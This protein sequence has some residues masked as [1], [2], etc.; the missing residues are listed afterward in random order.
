MTGLL[1]DGERKSIQP[2]AARLVDS[3]PEIEGMRQRLQQAVVVADWNDGV[4]RSRLAKLIDQKM[5][6]LEVILFDDTGSARKAANL[7]GSAAVL[8][9]R[10][11]V[12]T[13]AKSG[14]SL[15]LAGEK[16]SACVGMQLYLSEEWI[17]D[18]ERRLA[19]GIPETIQFKR[20]SEIA[21]ELLDRALGCGVRQ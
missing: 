14:A 5:P 21:I 4:M 19:A 10:S 18:A 11:V 2:L 15:H 12:W 20:K 6:A 9:G 13:I 3:D 16:R 17:D 8:W 7:Q 1:L